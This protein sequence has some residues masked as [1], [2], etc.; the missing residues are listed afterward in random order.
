MRAG[1]LDRRVRIEKRTRTQAP[2]GQEVETWAAVPTGAADNCVWMG[3]RDMRANERW[4]ADQNVA[5]IETVFTAHWAPAF[6]TIQPDTHRL[7]Y[8]SRVYEIHGIR[9][10]GRREGVEIAAAARGEARYG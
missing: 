3:K 7:V 4:A 10:V 1:D 9:E 2:G 5:Q 8:R 6:E